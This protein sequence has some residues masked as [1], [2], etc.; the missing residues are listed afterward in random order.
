[1][2]TR[3]A[4][5]ERLRARL[6]ATTATAVL[7]AAPLG[8]AST[9][10]AHAAG[11]RVLPAPAFL[12]R[13]AVGAAVAGTAQVHAT[14]VLQARHPNALA[15]RAALV[16][17]PGS[18]EY[19]HFLSRQQILAQY[20]PKPA[21]AAA[22]VQ[23]LRQ[24]G[25]SATDHGWTV[26][27]TAP[28]ARWTAL[29]STRLATYHW[30][31]QAFRGQVGAAT[32]PAWMAGA[33]SGVTGLTTF[34][35]PAP[36]AAA[37]KTPERS[38][39]KSA[40]VV[41]GSAAPA[42]VTASSGPLTVTATI[43]GGA[44][45]PT[46][47][48]V[49]AI[50]QVTWFGAPDSSAGLAATSDPVPTTST[51]MAPRV[52]TT[53]GLDGGDMVLTIAA[54]QAMTASEQVTVYPFMGYNG[55][56]IS[57]YTPVT[58][59]LPPLTWSGP[60]TLEALT[61]QGINQVY[62]AQRL[63]QQLGTRVPQV[64]VFAAGVPTP[65]MLAALSTF[66]QQNQ[67]P[68]PTVSTVSV[69][70][71]S[72]PAGTGWGFET[73]MDLQ[74]QGAAA[75]GA[76]ITVYS[77]PT[78]DV[79]AML[80]AVINHPVPAVSFSFGAEGVDAQLA[81]LADA[82]TVQGVSLLVSSGDSGSQSG[83]FPQ[84]FTPPVLPPAVSEPADLMPVTALGG[85]D[86]AVTQN[87]APVYTQAWGGTYLG[88][89]TPLGQQEM[90]QGKAASG[91]GYSTTTPVPSWQA[92]FL[93]AG[94]PG[95]GVPDIA[96]MA[97]PTTAGLAIVGRSGT[98]YIGGGTSQCAPLMAGWVADMAAVSGTDFGSLDP[99]LY[100]LA[101]VDPS[102]FTQAVRGDNGAYQITSPN[103]VPGTWNPVTGLGSPNIGAL[104]QV[105]MAGTGPSAFLTAP[106]AVPL[107]SAPVTVGAS[108]LNL[109]QPEYQFW[110]QN[111]RDG[112][113]TS[114]GAFSAATQF[115]FT[116]AVP[117]SYHVL[118]DA[119]AAAGGAVVPSDTATVR[120]TSSAAMVSGLTVNSTAASAVQPA[121]ASVSFTA[122]A[123]DPGGQPEYQFW[124]HGPS[125]QWRIVQNYSAANSYTAA[126]LAPGSYT[127]AVYALDPTQVAAGAWSQAFVY[128]TVVNVASAVTLS[129]PA[130]GTVGSPVAASAHATGLTDPVYQFWVQAPDGTWSQSGPYTPTSTYRFTPSQQGTYHVVVY[131]KDPYA[132]ST[133][134]FAVQSAAA[135]SVGS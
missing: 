97:N 83:N 70:T 1:M 130:T 17:E 43:P 34:I 103:N 69:S 82:L 125:G 29:L 37:K 47:M 15:K 115:T 21:S 3:F 118:V 78:F 110:V 22:L 27:A 129:V 61:A 71:G 42:S 9:G 113:W 56:P 25:F 40:A 134:Q 23:S 111:P 60:S 96:L 86:V 91:G 20:G 18:P 57:G 121:G 117:G 124:I 80:Q 114:S 95:R 93:P 39:R 123:A 105:A 100:Q 92:P 64:G 7:L 35:P 44:H 10:V 2:P 108:S 33:V 28:A 11:G 79:G 59:T 45:K 116:P 131:A 8:L 87:L 53:P 119:R 38:A 55:Y 66:S 122:N 63:T 4:P 50:L 52:F 24:Q 132:P 58:I 12:R 5:L 77:D 101:A 72:L 102:L 68:T 135:V 128:S 16:S 13:L 51:G 6:L 81:P 62:G 88:S 41:Q 109:S 85:T 106:S 19:H 65:A 76:H 99:L 107:S 98:A 30:H 104:A 120:V 94:S 46:G 32:L 89:L 48:P 36:V 127:V 14:L 74:D 31:G 73:T 54:Q 126:D 112:A 67:I 26:S 84:S 133:S 75:P 49:H 90:L